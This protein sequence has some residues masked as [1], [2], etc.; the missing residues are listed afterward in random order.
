M[1]PMQGASPVCFTVT[2][3]RYEPEVIVAVPSLFAGRVHWK[4]F[5]GELKLL[6]VQ[7]CPPRVTVTSARVYPIGTGSVSTSDRVGPEMLAEVTCGELLRKVYAQL[8]KQTLGRP[9]TLMRTLCW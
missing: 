5:V 7:G 9:F 6:I 3:G 1:D 2:T 8:P 4:L